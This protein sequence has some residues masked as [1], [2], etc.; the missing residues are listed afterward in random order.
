MTQYEKIGLCFQRA[1]E[2][3]NRTQAEVA[4]FLGCTYQAISNWECGR[5]RIDSVSLL[6]CLLWF[7]TDIYEF[8]ESCDFDVMRR[9]GYGNPAAENQLLAAYRAASDDDRMIVD[10]VLKKYTAP[11]LRAVAAHGGGLTSAPADAIDALAEQ[12]IP[13]KDDL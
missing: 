2:S 11:K 12:A 13:T 6:K 8:L 1:R 4:H 5:T 7:D 9:Y 3:A 10:T